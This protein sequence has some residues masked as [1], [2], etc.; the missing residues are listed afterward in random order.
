M[1]GKM[2]DL[3]PRDPKDKPNPV[4]RNPKIPQGEAGLQTTPGSP[5]HSVGN[6]NAQLRQAAEDP[7]DK[8]HHGKTTEIND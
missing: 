4:P 1:R 5:L 8:P 2:P 7:W 3:E 6:R